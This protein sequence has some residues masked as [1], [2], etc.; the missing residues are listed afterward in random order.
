MIAKL[1]LL[2]WILLT[3]PPATF[4][5][6]DLIKDLGDVG[7]WL[8]PRIR[9]PTKRTAFGKAL[10]TLRNHAV[11]DPPGANNCYAAV[12]HDIGFHRHWGNP[13]FGMR[14]QNLDS[15]WQDALK[16]IGEQF[17]HWLAL[18]DGF[19]K[20][21]FGLI[22]NNLTRRQVMESFHAQ[23]HGVCG[24]CDGPAGES[25]DDREAN[26][27]DHFFPKSQWPHLAIHPHNLFRVC[28]G[29]NSTW[30]LD[31]TPMGDGSAQGIGGTYHPEFLPGAGLVEVIAECA[32]PGS[33]RLSINIDDPIK[34]RR[35]ASLDGSL[36]LRE[37]WSNQ[38]NERL[39]ASVSELVSDAIFSRRREGHVSE[40]KLRE[41]IDDLLFRE[42]EKLG[43]RP[44]CL[45]YAAALRFQR[46][47]HIAEILAEER[48]AG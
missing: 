17:Y 41:I 35:A 44:Y 34:P 45:R 6:G 46:D 12:V 43:Q 15:K 21:R 5:K 31:N 8:F 47:N 40:E 19:C 25:S 10:D 9:K 30:K 23:S 42:T 7:N 33:R 16:P 27:C 37:R 18:G 13:G 4:A 2:K 11:T 14:F 24:Y 28:K 48:G 38:V 3:P 20:H 22:G 26:D 39:D 36:K 29:C 1:R 32:V